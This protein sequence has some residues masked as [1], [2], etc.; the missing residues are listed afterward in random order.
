MS[1]FR[2]FRVLCVLV[3]LVWTAGV[4]RADSLFDFN[5][6]AAGTA[7]TFSATNNGLTATFSSPSV[8]AGF[9]VQ[10]SGGSLAAP[11][12]GNVL[13]DTGTPGD[14]NIP[15]NIAFSSNVTSVSLAFALDSVSTIDTFLLA[16]FEGGAKIGEVTVIGS[17]PSGGFSFP[18]GTIAFSGSAFDSIQLVSTAPAFAINDVDAVVAPTVSAPEP[19]SLVLLG[20]GLLGLLALTARGKRQATP[21]AC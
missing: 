19:N 18:Q 9:S 17:V 11:L 3:L 16:A 14:E 20:M 21:I 7:T 8:P 2:S 15:L 12:D 5:S 10:S 1:T 4:A 13:L 6:I